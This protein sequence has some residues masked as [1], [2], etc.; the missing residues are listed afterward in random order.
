MKHA[1]RINF[2]ASTKLPRRAG[3]SL[4]EVLISVLILALGL[5]GLGAVFPVVIREQRLGQER[6]QGVLALNSA[7]AILANI[8]FDR[9][10][11][12]VGG[13]GSL[14]KSFWNELSRQG[15]IAGRPGLVATTAASVQNWGGWMVA[16]VAAADSTAQLVTRASGS[17]SVDVTVGIPVA[18]RLYPQAD[19]RVGQPQFV[20]DFAVQRVSP[21]DNLPNIAGE[22]PRGAIRA[23]VFVR[24]IDPQ[25]RIPPNAETL[26]KSFLSSGTDQR[27]PVAADRDGRPTLDGIG[28]TGT[29]T[30]SDLRTM[31]VHFL[32]DYAARGKDFRNRLYVKP[33]EVATVN[34][35]LARR[36][37]Q[38]LVDNLGN[39]YNVVGS[40]TQPDSGAQNSFPYLIVDPPIPDSVTE[41]QAGRDVGNFNSN[42]VIRQVVFSPVIPSAVGL[43]ELRP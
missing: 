27:V 2:D 40:A 9:E 34:W 23:A 6:V 42:E 26:M 15:P 21:L 12:L 13:T 25:I 16:K 37:G 36:P 41:F 43:V 22:Y 14:G 10:L 17:G 4:I 24:R 35:E 7:R 29:P 5:L 39:V 32:V 8:N 33:T 3:F 19:A 18:S 31:E 11:F 20:W 30:Y 28:V 1:R 38:R